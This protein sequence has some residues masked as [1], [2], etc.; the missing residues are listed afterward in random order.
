VTDAPHLFDGG[1]GGGATP[2]NGVGGNRIRM[3]DVKNDPVAFLQASEKV[4]RG[5]AQWTE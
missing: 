4:A 2:G 3:A 1:D 5:E